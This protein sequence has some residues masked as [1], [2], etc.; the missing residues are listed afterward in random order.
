[1]NILYFVTLKY[2]NLFCKFNEDFPHILFYDIMLY[3]FGKY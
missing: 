1:M 3:S 2:I